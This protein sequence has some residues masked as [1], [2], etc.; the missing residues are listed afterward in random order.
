MLSRKAA[1]QLVA[2]DLQPGRSDGS[3]TAAMR[4]AHLLAKRVR[5]I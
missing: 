2:A 4:K 3:R 5:T 1:N